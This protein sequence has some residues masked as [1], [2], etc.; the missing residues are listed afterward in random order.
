MKKQSNNNIKTPEDFNSLMDTTLFNQHS[1]A[2][3]VMADGEA[4]SL[5]AARSNRLGWQRA[6][7]E[8]KEK[9]NGN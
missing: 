9:Q 4:L 7:P 1:R 3:L 5:V 8:T 6:G 2:F